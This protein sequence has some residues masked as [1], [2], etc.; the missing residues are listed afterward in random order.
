M[1]TKFY[2]TADGSFGPLENDS[3]VDV[4][5]F[6]KTDWER[7]EQCCDSQRQELAQ[8]IEEKRRGGK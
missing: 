6:T 3:I 5:N 4:K 2:F 1:T 7:I 8:F